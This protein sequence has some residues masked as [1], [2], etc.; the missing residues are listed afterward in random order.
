MPELT[1][2][3]VADPITKP[4]QKTDRWW[5]QPPSYPNPKPNFQTLKTKLRSKMR[6]S[7]WFQNVTEWIDLMVMFG[8]GQWL[9]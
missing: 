3:L 8:F 7:G 5:Q 9:R 6:F 2:T 4:A 1:F